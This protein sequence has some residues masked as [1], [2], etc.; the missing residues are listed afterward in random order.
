M[1]FL[2]RSSQLLKAAVK[3]T[4]ER[5]LVTPSQVFLIV[6]WSRLRP[7]SPSLTFLNKKKSAGARSGEYG[8]YSNRWSLWASNQTETKGGGVQGRV[9]P[10]EKPLLG[11]Q[12]RPFQPQTPP[13]LAQDIDDVGHVDG[14]A[15]GGDVGVDEAARIKECEHHLLAAVGL[16]LCLQWP[17]LA[18]QGPLLA[19][20]FG[21]WSVVRNQGLVHSN[22]VV[23]HGEPAA[24]DGIDDVLADSH[25][26]L[27]L[28][29]GQQFGQ[30]AHF[31]TRP[32]SSCRIRQMVLRHTPWA[33][34]RDLVSIR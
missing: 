34:A 2:Q 12:L 16:H 17:R 4:A 29:L 18:L 3:S 21:L 22:N 32:K 24:L 7:S 9:V 33:A 8:G 30:R 25:S 11:Q 5:L 15:P 23:Q 10:V 28:H 31:L 27:F 14:G 26:F 19:H 1:H 6:S 20:S 13:E